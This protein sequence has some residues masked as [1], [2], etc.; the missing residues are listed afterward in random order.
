MRPRAI[1]ALVA[2][3]ALAGC[4]GG[5]DSAGGGGG[6]SGEITTLKVGVSS[7]ADLAPI[8]LG[9]EK[10]FFRDERLKL[11]LQPQQ[12]G[13]VTITGV[14][15]G[16]FQV[17]YSNTTS[18]LVASAKGLPLRA[19]APA[20]QV[21]TDPKR[22]DYTAVMVAKDSKVRDVGDL[23]GT[24]MA[25]N[26]LE[27]QTDSTVKAALKAKG[28]DPDSVKFTEIPFPDQVA[29]LQKGRVDVITPIE[30]FVTLGED[31][32][33]RT[34]LPGYFS[35]GI[36]NYT[37][38]AYFTTAPYMEQH[39]D[40]V[41]RLRRAIVRSLEYAKAHEAEVRATIPTFTSVKPALAKRIS[42]PVWGTTFNRASIDRLA[43][44]IVKDKLADKRPD[45]GAVLGAD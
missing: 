42:L 16:D 19:I 9:Q 21:G 33:L 10:G 28:V 18:L 35:T 15:S 2:L 27:S 31:A 45:V 5:D 34:V 26:T 23:A 20:A 25:A 7:I 13:S 43:D 39:A 11:D 30:P 17:G 12:G 1:A 37:T 32:G 41:D 40:V 36:P 44:L 24:T 4:G 3:A 22:Q 38:G 6:G 29:A 8:Y 14:A